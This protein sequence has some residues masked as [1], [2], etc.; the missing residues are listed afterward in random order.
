MENSRLNKLI[1]IDSFGL[2][3]V[4]VAVYLWQIFFRKEK[5]N[6]E[7]E[8]HNEWHRRQLEEMARAND[9][10]ER[11]LDEVEKLP[12]VNKG[13]QLVELTPEKKEPAP[14]KNPPTGNKKRK[15][16]PPQP[17]GKKP[18]TPAAP[19]VAGTI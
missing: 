9:L 3:I 4:V 2:I 15:T 19:V 12:A 8:E 16:N 7:L 14:R 10:L 11:Q 1:Q 5:P 13:G 18:E 17:Q 6:K